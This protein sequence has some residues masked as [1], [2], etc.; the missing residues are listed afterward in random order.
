MEAR[1]GGTWLNILWMRR[2]GW[3]WRWRCLTAGWSATAAPFVTPDKAM[4]EVALT[5]SRFSGPGKA[6]LQLTVPKAVLGLERDM[7]KNPHVNQ[8]YY[9]PR[10]GL[11]GHFRDL[12]VFAVPTNPKGQKHGRL[13]NGAIRSGSIN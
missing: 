8:R 4:Q 10:K 13:R 9:M 3:G 7:K 12:A 11:E 6:K 5:E 2:N 1:N